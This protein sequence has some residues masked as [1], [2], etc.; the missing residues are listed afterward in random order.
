MTDR[1]TDRKLV[2]NYSHVKQPV[3]FVQH[4][5]PGD[6]TFSE[7]KYITTNHITAVT[8]L[9]PERQ[10][11]TGHEADKGSWSGSDACT[12]KGRAKTDTHSQTQIDIQTCTHAPQVV[13]VEAFRGLQV[14]QH[15]A[16]TAH[17]NIDP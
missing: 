16:R 3:G 8:Q 7:K 14:I 1:H 17:Q 15:A 5:P 9:E 6:N 13:Q 4:H 12:T 10:T 2:V 11:Q